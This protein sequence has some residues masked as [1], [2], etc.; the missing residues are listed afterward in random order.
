MISKESTTKDI[1]LV[2]YAYPCLS[3]LVEVE[4]ARAVNEEGPACIYYANV[5]GLIT[6]GSPIVEGQKERTPIAVK[7]LG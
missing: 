4:E 1:K 6:S 5:N 2:G 3:F 7:R